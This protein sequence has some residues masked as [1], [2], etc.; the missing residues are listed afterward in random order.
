MIDPFTPAIVDAEYSNGSDFGSEDLIASPS[1]PFDTRHKGRGNSSPPLQPIPDVG[2]GG[3]KD[4]TGSIPSQGG[5]SIDPGQ[6]LQDSTV[7]TSESAGELIIRDGS[8]DP[9]DGATGDTLAGEVFDLNAMEDSPGF[10]G[11][12]NQRGVAWDDGSAQGTSRIPVSNWEANCQAEKPHE[13]YSS[14]NTGTYTGEHTGVSAAGTQLVIGRAI[15]LEYLRGSRNRN[16]DSEPARE[17]PAAPGGK[18]AGP[19]HHRNAWSA[20]DVD[21]GLGTSDSS[22]GRASSGIASPDARQGGRGRGRR[23]GALKLEVGSS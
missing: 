2:E 5:P 10:R 18:I 9:Q 12:W 6:H 21:S 15:T 14:E 13:E 1:G 8:S 19:S 4:D 11:T 17:T 23:T 16:D 7:P 22:L 3:N 20:S